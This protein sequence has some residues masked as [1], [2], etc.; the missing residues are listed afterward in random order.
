MIA[1]ARAIKHGINDLHY[2]SGEA[3]SKRHPEMIHRVCDNL[4][5]AGLDPMGIWQ[6]MEMT[7]MQNTHIKNTSIRIELSPPKEYTR[8]FTIDDWKTLWKD[9]V[10]EFD[11]YEEASS[12]PTHTADSKYTVW[13]HKESKGQVPHLHGLVCRLDEQ[14]RINNDHHIDRRAQFAAEQV[15]IKRGWVTAQDVSEERRE[16]MSADCMAV[17]CSMPTWSWQDYVMRLQIMGY[18]M[19]EKRNKAGEVCGYGVKRGNIY[20]KASR[21]GDGHNLTASKIEATW[22]ELHPVEETH[23][24][25]PHPLCYVKQKPDTIPVKIEADNEV[26]TRYVPDAAEQ[27]FEQEFSDSDI[28]NGPELTNLARAYFTFLLFPDIT[29]SCGGGGPQSDLPWGRDPKEDDY[30]F[31]QRCAQKAAEKLGVRKNYKQRKR[32]LHL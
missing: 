15:A 5:P 29:P 4:L 2:I 13:L 27:V 1:K 23:E 11:R 3:V 14:G 19:K 20:F 31:A 28:L 9:F 26:F 16:E 32:G 10:K 12:P 22:Q 18:E 7:M 17:L 21:L 8:D 24:V 6:S 25:R 30:D